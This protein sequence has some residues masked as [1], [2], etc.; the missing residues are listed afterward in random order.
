MFNFASTLALVAATAAASA[1]IYA[2]QADVL[3]TY[4][5]R[6]GKGYG[7]FMEPRKTKPLIGNDGYK[8]VRRT[9]IYDRSYNTINAKCM[10]LDPEDEVSISGVVRLQQGGKDKGTDIWADIEGLDYGRY[11]LNIHALG[12]LR[13]GCDS[14]SGIFNPFVSKSGYGKGHIPTPAPGKLDDLVRDKKGGASLD[15]HADVDLSGAHSV[16]G[17]SMVI[18]KLA[19]EAYGDEP[20]SEAQRVACCTIGLAG[21]AK[22]H[23][24]VAEEPLY[25]DLPIYRA[26]PTKGY[27]APRYW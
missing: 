12:D 11:E 5:W 19:E 15:M 13:D 26:A 3:P 16:I 4:S 21:E 14:T 1:D 27:K 22:R 20:A 10:L 23:S 9:D 24:Y 2:Q 7:I 18:T 6:K 17:R 25:Y 8:I